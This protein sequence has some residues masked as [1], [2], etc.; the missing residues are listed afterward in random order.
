MKR[1]IMWGLL[2][3]LTTGFSATVMADEDTPYQKLFK[4]KK[5]E[6][7]QSFLTARFTDK[8]D[9]YFELPKSMLGKDMLM[10]SSVEKTSD[11]G[12]AAYGPVAANRNCRIELFMQ[13][14][15]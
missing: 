13:K 6:T 4:D 3:A 12:T 7:A 8:G 15:R 9:L 5:V 10:P 1:M 2:L 14:F 11:G